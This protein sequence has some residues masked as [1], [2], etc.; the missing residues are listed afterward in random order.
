MCKLN[1]PIRVNQ[2]VHSHGRFHGDIKPLPD[3]SGEEAQDSGE[4]TASSEPVPP[5]PANTP[6]SSV[7]ETAGEKNFDFEDVRAALAETIPG[8]VGQQAHQD[9]V[10]FVSG[11]KFLSLSLLIS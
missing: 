6:V 11:E 8:F 4:N 5:T 3:S 2:D 1:G 7:G 9:S 10:R